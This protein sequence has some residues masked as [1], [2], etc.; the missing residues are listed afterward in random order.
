MA[1]T[2]THVSGAMESDPPLSALPALLEE[3]ATA[4]AEHPDVAVGHESGW[5]LSAFSRGALVWENVEEPETV[6]HLTDVDRLE[7]RR[8]FEAVAM[9]DVDAVSA[10]PW[11]PGYR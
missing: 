7:I 5:T 2:I 8:L 6:G 4:D 10:L 11:R 1:F 9:G 3:L